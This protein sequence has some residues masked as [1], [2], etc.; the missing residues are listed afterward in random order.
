MYQVFLCVLNDA[1]GLELDMSTCGGVSVVSGSVPLYGLRVGGVGPHVDAPLPDPFQG[2]RDVEGHATH[3]LYLHLHHLAV[4]EGAQPLV[5]GAAGDNVPRVEGQDRDY[6]R[7]GGDVVA[8][9]LRNASEAQTTKVG[10]S[11]LP[12]LL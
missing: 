11:N 8:Q 7:C 9:T 5:V 1:R 10:S 3:P 2:V 12:P 4:L 6:G